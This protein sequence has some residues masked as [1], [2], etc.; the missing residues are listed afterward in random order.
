MFPAIY[1]LRAKIELRAGMLG[2]AQGGAEKAIKDASA[3]LQPGDAS[4]GL[5][6]AYY[7]L[8]K[9]LEAKGMHGEALATM[10]MSAQMLE[11]AV[12]SGCSYTQLALTETT[13]LASRPDSNVK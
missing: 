9:A 1:V 7:F 5:G 4:A 6:N 12:G 13:N 2:A 11:K 10:R 3:S 8:A